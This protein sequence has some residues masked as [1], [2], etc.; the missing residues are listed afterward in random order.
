VTLSEYERRVISDIER[1]FALA[2]TSRRR[3][4]RR[5]TYLAAISVGGCAV[6]C[7]LV[8]TG[9]DLLPAAAAASIAAVVGVGLGITVGRLWRSPRAT[10]AQSQPHPAR[11][12]NTAP[13]A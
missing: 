1:G 4:R 9:L 2:D 5:V 7:T 11:R 6:A 8:L 12:P 3:R 10:E 13:P